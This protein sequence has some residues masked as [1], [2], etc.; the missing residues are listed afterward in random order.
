MQPLAGLDAPWMHSATTALG[1][2]EVREGGGEDKRQ[3][4]KLLHSYVANRGLEEA[5]E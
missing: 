1:R 2:E 4:L 3:D 5:K